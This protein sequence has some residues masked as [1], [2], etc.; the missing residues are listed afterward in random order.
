VWLE[1]AAVEPSGAPHT[2]PLR[3]LSKEANK[4]EG[5][6]APSVKLRRQLSALVDFVKVASER[7]KRKSRHG[8]LEY[9]TVVETSNL[10]NV[11]GLRRTSVAVCIRGVRVDVGHLDVLPSAL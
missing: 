3:L 11:G 6:R 1:W 4:K 10:G 5:A 2:I 7:I 8:L 9:Q